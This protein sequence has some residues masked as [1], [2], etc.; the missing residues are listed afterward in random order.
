MNNIG[1]F[2][3][4]S[5]FYY[6]IR[7]KFDG[8]KLNYE[9]Y[10][11]VVHTWG[12]ITRATAYCMQQAGE[13]AGFIAYLRAHGFQVRYKRP[14]LIKIGDRTIKQCEWGVALAVDALANDCDHV[15]LGISN[16][17]YIPLVKALQDRETKVTIFASCIPTSLREAADDVFEINESH[18]QS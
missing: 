15:V 5:D 17:D 9:L 14:R 12:D 18:L 11:G 1:V 10:R 3:D 7:R 6:R 2:V 4:V 13:A 8:A 16:P